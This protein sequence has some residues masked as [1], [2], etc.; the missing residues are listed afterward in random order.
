MLQTLPD[1]IASPNKTLKSNPNFQKLSENLKLNG[2]D[3]NC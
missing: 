3:S 2:R 1:R